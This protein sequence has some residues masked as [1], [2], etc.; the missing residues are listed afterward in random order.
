MKQIPYTKFTFTVYLICIVLF[1]YV[2][3]TFSICK[4][5]RLNQDINKLHKSLNDDQ[6]TK[7]ITTIQKSLYT[8]QINGQI[9]RSQEITSSFLE[10]LKTSSKNHKVSL[11]EIQ[12]PIINKVE[13]W[14]KKDQTFKITGDYDD[15][16]WLLNYIEK[17]P[18]LGRIS[19]F[20]F[21]LQSDSENNKKHL[22]L[23]VTFLSLQQLTSEY[24][25]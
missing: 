13:K 23:Y 16:I 20:K 9:H 1:S 10:L 21:I 4:T 19:S 22:F 25:Q 15:L 6:L 3:Y 17:T 24:N 14:L 18:S 8:N 2:I 12:P 11:V 7:K 5:V